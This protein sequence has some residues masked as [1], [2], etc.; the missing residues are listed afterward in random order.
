MDIVVQIIRFSFWSGITVLF[1]GLLAYFFNKKINNYTIK[2]FIITILMSFGGGVILSAVCFVLIPEGLEKTNL[3]RGLILFFSGSIAFLLIDRAIANKGGSY[4]QLMAML[5]DF[6]PEALSLGAIFALDPRLGMVL[7]IF[8]GIQNLPESFNAYF[9]LKKGKFTDKSIFI[10]FFC[11]SFVGIISAL[12]GHFILSSHEELTG[13]VML[14]ASGGIIY[15]IF[16]DIAPK[17]KIENSWVPA[18]GFNLGIGLGII[19]TA[20]G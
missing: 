7:A 1:G 8:I 6:V 20:I 18:L 17:I 9:E 13:A 12:V 15:I 14:L 16:L 2:N 19:G 4:A 3:L 11:L 5:L 10:L